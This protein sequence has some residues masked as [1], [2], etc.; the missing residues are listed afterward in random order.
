[1]FAKIDVNGPDAH[2]LFRFLKSASRGLLGA[3]AIKWNFTKFLVDRHG[4]VRGRFGPTVAPS[5]LGSRIEPLL[6]S[7]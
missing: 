5:S 1:M 6:Q 3:E 7:A 4:N 2:P